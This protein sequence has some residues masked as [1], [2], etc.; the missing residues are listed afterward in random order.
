MTF[1]LVLALY[2]YVSYSLQVIGQKLNVEN[3]WLAWIPFGNAYVMFKAAG[4][5]IWWILLMLVPFVNMFVACM[6][7]IEITKK[8]G[9]S[10]WLLLL[11]F[12]PLLNLALFGYFAFG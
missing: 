10:P 6:V 4:K 2:A 8:L 5:P 7:W 3:A 9:K 11:F 12:V 1:I